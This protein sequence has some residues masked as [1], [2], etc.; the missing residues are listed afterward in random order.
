MSVMSDTPPPSNGNDHGRDRTPELTSRRDK[1]S[2]DDEVEDRE[3]SSR[4]RHRRHE[5]AEEEAHYNGERRHRHRHRDDDRDVD[6]DDERTER[7]RRHHHEDETE[8][9]REERR[10]RRR[11]RE[12]ARENGDERGHRHSSRREDDR[13]P[14][15]RHGRDEERRDSRYRERDRSRESHRSHRS[16]RSRDVDRE[17]PSLAVREMTREEKEAEREKRD[18]EM[19]EERR[20][21][22]RARDE[23]FAEMDR[24]RERERRT[25][26]GSNGRP[27]FSPRD[28]PRSP[29]RRGHSPS[30]DAPPPPRSP[31]PPKDPV[32]QLLDEVD[33]ESRSVFV[34][35]LAARLTSRDLGMFFE[36]KLGRGSVRDARVVTDRVSRRS[37]GIAYVELDAVELVNRAL[38]LSGTVVMG[39]PIS[40]QLTEAERNRQGQVA[41][42]LAAGVTATSLAAS[43]DVPRPATTY[44]QSFPPLSTG[45]RVPHGVEVDAHKDASIPYHRLFVSN[46]ATSLSSDDLGQVFEAF[47]EIEFVD[48]HYSFSG[49]S[50]GTAYVQFKDLRSAQMALDAMN[51]FE[52]AGRTIR[53]Q[54]VQ[55]RAYVAEQI[56]DSGYTTRLDATQRQQL[57]FKLARTEPNVNLSLS[58]PKSSTPAPSK[59]SSSNPTLF[60][61]VSNMFNPE[62]ET[63]RNWD[64]DLA[65]DVKGE[66]ESKYGKLRR[67]K[68]DKMSAGD[69]YLEFENL[70]DAKAAAKGLGGRFFGGRQLQATFISEALF[71]AHM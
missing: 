9:E 47:G 48:L 31:P 17:R 13:E 53:V 69:V 54:S 16:H 26:Q 61:S 20:E 70:G 67:I 60:L 30:Y 51:G 68:V 57:M 28:R 11:E 29:P 4:H 5:N 63:E 19:Q 6:Q 12:E 3:R 34:S 37:K 41:A 24:E 40:I 1:R 44:Q 27:P 14:R 39:I 35:Q 52:L 2:R 45:L 55:E 10:R 32:N 56:E 23:R 62:E 38:A 42:A 8:E 25:R 71:K 50:K 21:A 49:E 15:D 22:A 33:S 46:L 43:R 59:S 7:K 64:L 66:V 65:E 58:A 18:R 36:D